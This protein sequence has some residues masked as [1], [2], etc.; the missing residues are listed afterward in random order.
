MCLCFA[1]WMQYYKQS[2]LKLVN[3]NNRFISVK[4]SIVLVS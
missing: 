2:W 1:M 3:K 4:I